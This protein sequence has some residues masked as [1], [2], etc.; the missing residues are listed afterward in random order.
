MVNDVT[1]RVGQ[2][3]T[4]HEE[5]KCS[6]DSFRLVVRHLAK[7]NSL[8]LCVASGNILVEGDGLEV[9]QL[10]DDR[11]FEQEHG[12]EDATDATHSQAA[13]F[14]FLKLHRVVHLEVEWVETHFPWDGTV[15]EHVYVR[16]AALVRDELNNAAEDE[17][18]PQTSGRH[19]EEGLGRQWVAELG[20]GQVHE[21][22]H[23]DPEEGKHTDA[24]VLDLGLLQPLDVHELAQAQRV[25][26]G[27]TRHVLAQVLGLGQERHG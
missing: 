19:L 20:A 11:R 7:S 27:V 2:S 9:E 13:V 12:M 23:D 26:A 14:D 24:T 25:E 6:Y 5:Q 1:S 8:F 3:G 10:S 15:R 21:L 17:D 16:N 18:L 4:I 22:L